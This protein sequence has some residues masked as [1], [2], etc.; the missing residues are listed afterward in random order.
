MT[1]GTTEYNK[2]EML[3]MLYQFLKEAGKQQTK[4]IAAFKDANDKVK[5]KLEKHGISLS[6]FVEYS[7]W[8]DAP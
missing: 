2:D 3:A 5:E 4:A 7:N 6:E 8:K 1:S